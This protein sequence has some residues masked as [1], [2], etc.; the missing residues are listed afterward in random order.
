MDV[1]EDELPVS[2]ADLGRR[3]SGDASTKR[4][5]LTESMTSMSGLN[6]SAIPT[7]PAFE[8]VVWQSMVQKA[9]LSV[10]SLRYAC[11]T[12]FDTEEAG[13]F[14]ATGFIVDAKR[15]LILTNR[16]VVSATIFTG[17]AILH[18]KEEV[19]VFAIYRDPI[20][21]FGFLKFDP[22]KIKYMPL[23]EIHLS[24][25]RAKVGLEVRVVGNDAGETLS[26]LAGTI[27][28]LDRNRYGQR[29]YN[30]FNT[31]YIQG[32]LA[33]SGGSS[34][35][36]V[37][38]IDGHCVA[39]HA[40]G[41]STASTDFFLPLDRVTRALDCLRRDAHIDRGTIQTIWIHRPFD[42]CRRLGLSPE[43]EFKIRSL[44]PDETG[45]LVAETIV[46][47]G[48]GSQFLEESDILISVDDVVITKFLPLEVVLDERIGKQIK[49]KIERGGKEFEYFITVQDLHSITPDRF[50]EIGSAVVNNLSY[51]L[52]SQYNVPCRGVYVAH[53]SGMLL[54]GG[55]TEGW[56]ISH[57]DH[58]PTPNLDVFIQVM[59]EIPDYERIAITYYDIE[60]VHKINMD[61]VVNERHWTSFKM[62]VR[63][64]ATGFWDVVKLPAA[65]PPRPIIPMSTTF[66]QMEDSLGACRDLFKSICKVQ[67]YMPFSLDGVNRNF[68]TG[69][70]IVVD[71]VR[72]IAIVGRNVVPFG[73]GDII[74]TFADSL[75]VRGKLL[76]L[77]DAH[78][79]AFISYDPKLIGDT[80]VKSAPMSPV[81][82][83][84][85]SPI[86]LVA[87]NHNF[88]PTFVNTFVTDITALT[89]PQNP[90]P[91]Y[92]TINFDAVTID[93][94]VGR[95][96]SSGVLA[97]T[98]GRVQAIWLTFQSTTTA[99][100]RISQYELG[101]RA[102]CIQPVLA[103]LQQHSTSPI[104]GFSVELTPVQ[105]SRARDMGL[106]DGW[107]KKVEEANPKKRQ[108]FV[109]RQIVT[110]SNTCETLK[111]LDLILTINGKIL[112]RISEMD[113]SANWGE[114][115][116]MVIVR[117]KKE[118][119]LRVHTDELHGSGTNRWVSWAGATLQPPHPSACLQ[120]ST[121]PSRVYVSATS[122][123]SPARMYGLLSTSW[124]VSV[125]DMPTPNLDEFV[126]VII[127]VKA[128]LGE[129]G[130]C[131]VK[132]I[133]F[134][135]VPAVLS[136][137]L[138]ERYFPSCEFVKDDSTNSGWRTNPL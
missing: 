103:K 108:L 124:I 75:I 109:V 82:I 66:A 32:A 37:L 4:V 33:L 46:P 138:N 87:L 5:I 95:H 104:R 128:K 39:L 34:G 131:R 55:S 110:G 112:T 81:E 57:V 74:I 99:S 38:D 101:V 47:E 84:Q 78:G 118:M 8:S 72:G 97:D 127:L 80:P 79:V 125:N 9:A 105:M 77:D 121:L 92:R 119:T 94:P 123:G 130:Y 16:H 49:M 54:L 13:T 2:Q 85:G 88:M 61:I 115:V 18:D 35:S 42:E 64:D 71:A 14:V 53:A 117:G 89:I 25:E 136:I 41:K 114:S 10:V 26:V 135:L 45:M 134:D 50:V 28:R 56:I 23:Q 59:Q 40:G 120:S 91:R 48:P 90:I 67:Y 122:Q 93:T 129:T 36:P 7:S 22:S 31:F 6:S 24:P 96:C 63:N 44:F 52:A 1:D 132:T 27:S 20:H 73:M 83:S 21:D 68:M 137:K 30:D 133:S 116:E 51:Q 111:E 11:V 113:V 3:K 60:D 107:V 12:K 17:E 65:S 98:E 126:K 106:S 102:S 100:G 58:K 19:D 29:T 70:G 86:S 15:G 43:L 62:M 69:A 76:Y